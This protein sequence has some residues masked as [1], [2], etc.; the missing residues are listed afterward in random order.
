MDLIVCESKVWIF[1]IWIECSG[2]QKN[3]YIKYGLNC[4][5]IKSIVSQNIDL[6]VWESEVHFKIIVW[7]FKIIICTSK[8]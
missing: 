6:I 5:G 8:S 4:M 3:G 2:N 1:K 7:H